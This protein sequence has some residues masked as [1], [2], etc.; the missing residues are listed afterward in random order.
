MIKRETGYYWVKIHEVSEWEILWYS[1]SYTSWQDGE[2]IICY[3]DEDLFE[4]DERKI[5]RKD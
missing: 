1:Q 4:I 5:E 3:D 2:E